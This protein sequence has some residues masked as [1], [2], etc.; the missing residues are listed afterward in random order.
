M[1]HSRE[2]IEPLEANDA[3]DLDLLKHVA[4]GDGAAFGLLATTLGPI[5]K[6]VLFRIG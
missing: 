4:N 2:T 5:R 3:S 1:G 6:R